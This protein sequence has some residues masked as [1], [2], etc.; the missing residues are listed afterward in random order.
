M[1]TALRLGRPPIAAT[2][3]DPFLFV[4][5]LR[6]GLGVIFEDTKQSPRKAGLSHVPFADEKD[7]ATRS[8]FGGRTG[9]SA[10]CRASVFGF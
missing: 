10:T 7:A 6:W 4:C 1:A 3:E 5:S 2:M 8:W 9:I